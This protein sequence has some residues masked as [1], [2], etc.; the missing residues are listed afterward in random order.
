MV[1]GGGAQGVLAWGVAPSA[2]LTHQPAR[3][4]QGDASVAYL[5]D[6]SVGLAVDL[7]DGMELRGCGPRPALARRSCPL[8]SSP[9]PRT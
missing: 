9:L 5:R 8:A 7:M 2:H 3:D 1:G 4:T 6:E